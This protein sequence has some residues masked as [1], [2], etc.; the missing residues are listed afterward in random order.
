M[1][2]NAHTLA[3][4][5]TLATMLDALAQVGAP[6][7]LFG[8]LVAGYHGKARATGDVDMIVPTRFF[9]P[10]QAGLE[11]RGYD[12]RHFAY[13]M[14]I[15]RR[16]EPESVGDFVML[17]TNPVLRAA[18]AATAP[19]EI[20]GLPVSV[21]RR[22]VFVA[23][24]FEAAVT[25][26]R[27][28]KDRALDVADIR[29]VLEREFGPEDERLAAEIAGKMHPGAVTDLG[30]LLDDLRNGRWPT[31]VRRAEMRAALLVRRGLAPLVTRG[32]RWG[33]G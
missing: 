16:G 22:G 8:G 27:R 24:K 4:L 14:K 20:L 15:Y 6:H 7:A 2:E 31:V 1:R 29:G 3:T 30:A 33:R 13:L 9:G 19:G 10:L 11:Q 12:V 23:L 32:I 17:E 21:V 26:K 18:F 28:P 5:A 25:P